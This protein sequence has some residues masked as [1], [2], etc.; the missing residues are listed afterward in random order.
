MVEFCGVERV[1]TEDDHVTGVVTNLGSVQCERFVNCGGFW[2]RHIGQMSEPPVKVPL[3]PVEHYY[4]HT[5]PIEGLD[6]MTP[7]N[8]RDDSF[9]N[10]SLVG[11]EIPHNF[12]IEI[13]L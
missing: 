9:D 1:M 11:S 12:C 8:S 10:K 5:K 4:L 2:A 3:H 6:P 13:F 7:G